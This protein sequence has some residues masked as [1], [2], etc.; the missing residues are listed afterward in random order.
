[1]SVPDAGAE[2]LWS[3]N[4]SDRF[5]S[6][7]FADERV[8]YDALTGDT[9]FLEPLAVELVSQLEHCPQSQRE[10]VL[11]LLDAFIFSPDDDVVALTEATLAKLR[12]IGL[13]V[14]IA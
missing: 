7:I 1:M 2:R 8:V 13:I 11:K 12:G 9:H 6:R 14:N 4:R 3:V 10:L 5:I